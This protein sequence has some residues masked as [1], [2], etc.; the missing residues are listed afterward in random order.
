MTSMPTPLPYISMKHEN[1]LSVL[2][3]GRITASMFASDLELLKL[4]TKAALAQYG[5]S[6]PTV[7]DELWPP[8]RKNEK[9]LQYQLARIEYVTTL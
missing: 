6:W 3:T 8:Y 4:Q 1:A 7:F 2:A 9:G 5:Y